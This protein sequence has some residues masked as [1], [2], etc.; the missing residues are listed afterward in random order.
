MSEKLLRGSK[1]DE[2]LYSLR[3]HRVFS[4]NAICGCVQNVVRIP[5]VRPI[6]YFRRTITKK[7][8]VMYCIP[9]LIPSIHWGY[10]NH[11]RPIMGTIQPHAAIGMLCHGRISYQESGCAFSV[12]R[13]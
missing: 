13:H 1:V 2:A 10:V 6:E 9:E 11:L 4:L 5:A 3:L 8:K 7:Q 12:P